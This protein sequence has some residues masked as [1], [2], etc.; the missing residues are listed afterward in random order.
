M[1]DVMGHRRFAEMVRARHVLIWLIRELAH[2]SY[3][4]IALYMDRDHTSIM[5]AVHKVNAQLSEPG[6][7]GDA[8]RADMVEMRRR[9]LDCYEPLAG[10]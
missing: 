7:S 1:D 2:V 4:W 9:I 6:R 5:H 10:E 3:P 8:V